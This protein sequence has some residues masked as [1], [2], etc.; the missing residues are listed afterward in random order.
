MSLIDCHAHCLPPTI[1]DALREFAAG[2]YLGRSLFADDGFSSLEKHLTLMDRFG[3][4]K[5]V[6]NYGNLLIPAARARK[7]PM[8][9]VVKLVNDYIAE[10]SRIAPGRFVP[11]AAVDPYGGEAALQELDRAVEKLG[12]FGISLSTN[13]DGR[14]LDDPVYEPIFE[15]AK[16]WNMPLWVHPGQVPAAWQQALG[17]NNRY[18]N[19][20][21]GFLLDDMLCLIKMITANV[22]D[23]WWGVKFVFCQLGGFLPFTM[24]RFVEYCQAFYVDTH[25]ADA[26]AIHCA[27]D[28]M[29]A[30]RIVLGGDYPISPPEIGLGYTI[31]QLEK[32]GLSTSDR[33][34]IERGNASKLLNLP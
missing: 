5:E 23:R 31:P 33:T 20:G 13:I 6:I 22:F 29:T 7:L 14:A 27:L 9:E 1:L 2:S 28:C 21:V 17:L 3:V 4:E 10:A 8:E 19:S 18:L 30:D 24:G 32:A 11:A 26:S 15:R 12:L 25:T 16:A 34:K